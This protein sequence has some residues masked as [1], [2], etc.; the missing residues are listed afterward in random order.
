MKVAELKLDARQ[1][2]SA[3]KI[4]TFLLKHCTGSPLAEYFREGLAKARSAAA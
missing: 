3:A 4:Y 2:Q 1:P